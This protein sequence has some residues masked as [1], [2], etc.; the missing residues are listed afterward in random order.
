MKIV[1]TDSFMKI[2]DKL[3]LKM[4]KR[5]EDRLSIFMREPAHPILK[6]HPLKGNMTG[7]RA[8]SVSG[9]YRVIFQISDRDTVKLIDIGTHNKVY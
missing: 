7:C 6:V 9:N 3:P 1:V 5:F 8:F 4:R 2:L